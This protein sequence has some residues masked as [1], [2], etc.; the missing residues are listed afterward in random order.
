MV[1]KTNFD[2]PLEEDVALEQTKNTKTVEETLKDAENIFK[3]FLYLKDMFSSA[4]IF[5]KVIKINYFDGVQNEIVP[6]EKDTNFIVF[7]NNK[8]EET[9]IYYNSND[10]LI[11]YPYE[12]FDLPI[13]KGDTIKVTGT[14]NVIQIKYEQR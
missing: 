14:L 13:E 6:I 12:Q 1:V 7:K 5:N 8:K 10:K 3:G 4:P 2:N 11:L 9:E